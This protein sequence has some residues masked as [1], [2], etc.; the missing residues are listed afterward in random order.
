MFSKS[1]EYGLRAALY[2]AQ[3]TV[4]GV[5]N[6]RVDLGEISKQLEL[7]HHF[8]SKVLQLL[9]KNK[10]LNSSRGLKG[11]FALN[12]K[13]S[14]ISLLNIV[15][16]I[17]GMDKFNDCI[18]GLKECSDLHPCPVHYD[19]KPVK[20]KFIKLL[21]NKSLEDLSKDIIKGKVF[22]IHRKKS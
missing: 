12:R 7:P 1:C 16:A 4:P 6:K 10:I 2:V 13:P 5:R 3:I 19:Y 20:E 17:D 22:V 8:L 14:K 15:S 21:S 9:V 18:L 11:G